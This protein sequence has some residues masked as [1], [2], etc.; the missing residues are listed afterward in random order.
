MKKLTVLLIHDYPLM[1]EVYEKAFKR[2]NEK[3]QQID[4]NI[5]V[6]SDYCKVKEQIEEF[7]NK[8]RQIDLVVLDL[9]PIYVNGAK[10][11][12]VEEMAIFIRKKFKDT[13][14]LVLSTL[15]YVSRVHSIFKSVNPDGML[16]KKDVDF[17]ELVHAIIEVINEPPYYSKTIL[18]IL[19]KKVSDQF[20][21]DELDR[22]ILYELSIGSRVKEMTNFI[23]LSEAAIEKRKRQLKRVFNVNEKGNR[24]LI[25]KA[26]AEGY[27]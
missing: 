27:I 3:D 19:R 16:M 23:P 6:V 5:H 10:M 13:K 20:I 7:E 17:S 25:L 8:K 14:I 24:E 22:K 4:F 2:V 12:T 15:E 18:K 11:N 26:K 1:C 9:R 21:L